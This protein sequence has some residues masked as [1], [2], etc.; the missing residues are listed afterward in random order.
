MCI[1]LTFPV[2]AQCIITYILQCSQ[3]NVEHIVSR[4]GIDYNLAANT[5]IYALICNNFIQKKGS[6]NER[7][8]NGKIFYE[9]KPKS[10]CLVQVLL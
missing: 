1:C 3:Y 8:Q 6:H 2:E 7:V 4:L 9:L 10:Y 5:R